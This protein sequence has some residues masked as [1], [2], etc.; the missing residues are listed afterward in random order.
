[1][2]FVLMEPPSVCPEPLVITSTETV[3]STA[4]R[5]D[6]MA[7]ATEAHGM[8]GGRLLALCIVTQRRVN[9]S[10]RG[11]SHLNIGAAQTCLSFVAPR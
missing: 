2:L 10:W 3:P 7:S 4:V 1:M 6:W 8:V 11:P 9:E 5:S